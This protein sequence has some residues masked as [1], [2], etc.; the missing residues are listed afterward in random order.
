MFQGDLGQPKMLK[1][2]LLL[3]IAAAAGLQGWMILF[4][5]FAVDV[6]GLNGQQIGV[7]GSVREIPGLLALFVVYVLLIMREHRLAALSIVITG[8]G[9]ILTGF[10]PSYAGLVL[11]T[12]VISFGFHYFETTNQS[13]TLQ[14]FDKHRAPLVFGKLRSLSAAVNIVAGTVVFCLG[15]FF[16]YKTIFILL[17][18]FVIILG[19][20]GFTQNPL[21]KH[22]PPQR[23]NMVLRR[24]YCLFYFLTFMSG[25]RRQIFIA[26]AVFLLVKEF[27]CSVV[28]VAALFV[29]NNMVNYFL[30]PMIGRAIVHYGERKVLT[31][32]YVSLVVV[33]VGYAW[34][35]SLALV[36]FLYIADH[37]FFNFAIAIRTY[38]QKIAAPEDIAPS[39]AVSFTINHLAAVV[40]PVIGG[41]LWM[42]DYRIPFLAGAA[43][44]AISLIAVQFIRIPVAQN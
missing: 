5:N 31:L 12:L 33:F 41:A 19:L 28:Q 42:I 3:T 36:M 13:L 38:F 2:L 25:A 14:Y 34:A 10:M 16:E 40:L 11:S 23:Q 22:L 29:V 24:K 35:D 4:N 44:S 7:I 27:D 21:D 17:G 43:M 15:F 20:W 37:I 6:A 1:F 9:S 39:M 18:V 30:S 32:E 26:F 8:V